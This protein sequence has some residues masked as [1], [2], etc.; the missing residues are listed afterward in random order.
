M[1]SVA[2]K[3]IALR[4]VIPSDGP[5]P[6]E[7]LATS[8]MGGYMERSLA[9][10]SS[11]QSRWQT[12]ITSRP[13]ETDFGQFGFPGLSAQALEETFDGWHR[14]LTTLS[15]KPRRQDPSEIIVADRHIS[16]WLNDL[17]NHC[18]GIGGNGFQWGLNSTSLLQLI[19]DIASRIAGL[20]RQQVEIAKALA[21]Q[22]E[23]KG[24]SE[25]DAIIEA[26]PN[27]RSILEQKE[28]L[29]GAVEEIKS[30]VKT[31]GD[32]EKELTDIL[33]DT[34]VKKEDTD[35]AHEDV[36]S[37]YSEIQDLYDSA[38]AFRKTSKENSDALASKVTDLLGAVES[39]QSATKTAY[40]SL[41]KA[42]IDVRKQGLAGAFT[43]RA[44]KVSRERL[45]WG[46]VFVV[47]IIFL[48]FL[49][50]DFAV[51]LPAYTYEAVVVALL[52]RAA[53]AAPGVWM[54]WYSAKQLG[55]LA[56]VQEDYEY[57][58]A[59]AL[60]FQSYKNEA[61]DIGKDELKEEL[62]RQAIESFGDNPVRL[63]EHAKS[64]PA[65]PLSDL[66]KRLEGDE[67]I[68]LIKAVRGLFDP[69]A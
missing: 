22:L 62:L 19:D 47:S 49:A 53:L 35:K 12:L 36:K 3:I 31:S 69:K 54:G 45:L 66:L 48:A 8:L 30:H 4:L 60:A 21:K 46:V 32:I 52:R 39:A 57:K 26:G 24:V 28:H 18:N 67:T 5:L 33:N 44:V 34:K 42:L 13:N 38:E 16:V 14:S 55:R 61:V 2:E 68:K 41:N 23:R 50:I 7:A 59:T 9:S 29:A 64:E 27:A 11:L 25:I 65:S 10:L 63:Y 6:G 56:R 58:A 17:V 15:S 20:S 51:D 40:E 1:G 37:R 43:E